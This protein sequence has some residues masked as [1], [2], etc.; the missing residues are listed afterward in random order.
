MKNTLYLVVFILGLWLIPATAYAQEKELQEEESAAVSLE[1]YSDEFQESF[2]EGLK[3]KGIENYDRAIVHFLECKRLAPQNVDVDHELAKAYI[4]LK[5]FVLAQDHATAAVKGEP[6]NYWFLN[7]LQQALES[8][9]YSLQYLASEIP[10]KNPKLRQNMVLLYYKNQQYEEALQL[11]DG[12]TASPFVAEMRFKIKESIQQRDEQAKEQET[13][14]DS[15][16]QDDPYENYSATMAELLAQNNFEEL[17]KISAEAL[18]VF[19]AQAYF[20][21]VHGMALQKNKKYKQAIAI[22]ESGLDYL[23]DDMPLANKI[24][25]ELADAYRTLGDSSKSNMY[26]S[27]IKSGL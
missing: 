6:E 14:I 16:P 15:T 9:G 7:T 18:E 22:L 5:Q 12:I 20:Y 26:L 3:Q 10:L 11:L 13:V 24:Y 1:D 4:S 8:Q 21:Y 27:K 23:I 2:F 25:K 17:E 19:P